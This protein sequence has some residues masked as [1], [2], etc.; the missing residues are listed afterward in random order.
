MLHVKV[1]GERSALDDVTGEVR[2][3]S[4]RT[5]ALIAYLALHP[6]TPQ[7]RTR[8]AET[9]W[10]DSEQQQALTN[11]RREL[12]ELRRLLDGD[13]S[14]VVTG[15]DLT[16][17]GT[18]ACRVDLSEHLAARERAG[19]STS[20]N[21]DAL[22]VHG[23]QAL[24]DYGGDLLPGLYDDWV[25]EQRAALV[26]GARE[27]CAQVAAAAAAAQ[28]WDLAV[29]VARRRIALDPLDETAYRE[30]MRLQAAHGDRAGA[31]S[32]YHRCAAV[33]EEQLGVPPDPESQRLRDDLVA[34]AD[35]DDAPRPD[36]P[37][38]PPR[39]TAGPPR[40]GLVARGRELEWLERVYA[41]VE[42]GALRTVLVTGEPGVGKSRLVREL[43]HRVTARGARVATAHCYGTADRLPLGPVAEWLGEPALSSWSE[44][45]PP[46]WRTEVERLL[47]RDDAQL[48]SADTRGVVD[49]WQR[50]HFFHGLCEA[51]RPPGR[52]VVL[53]LENLQWCDQE[54]LE[55][56]TFLRSLQPRR[57]VLV[58][59]TA[60]SHELTASPAHTAWV[61]RA[62]AVAPVRELAVRPLGPD[63]SAELL[64]RLS[65]RIGAEQAALLH[66]AS[67]GFPLH[68]VEAV[69]RDP[70]GERLTAGSPD[71]MAVLRGRFEALGPECRAVVELA[72][73]VGR[74]FRL[75]LLCAAS[76]LP[77]QA[78]VGAV[79]E[80]WRLRI[81]AVQRD[82]YDFS[83]DLLRR[84]AYEQLTPPARWLLH[85]R[86]ATALEQLHAHDLDPVAGRLADQYARAGSPDRACDLFH[87]AAVLADDVFAYSDA[88]ELFGRSL[89]LLADLPPG[90]GRDAR[91]IRSLTGLARALNASRGY[92]DPD[93]ADALSRVV[94]L[95]EQAAMVPTTVDALVGLWAARFVQGDILRA[96]EIAVKALALS[97]SVTDPG[98]A[99]DLLRA[100]AHFA[101]GG[102]TLSLGRPADSLAHFARATALGADDASLSIGSHPAVHAL[103]WSAHAHWLLGSPDTARECA[104]EAIARARA[105]AHPY[106]LTITLGYAAL[107]HQLLD[108]RADLQA[109]ADELEVVSRRHGFAYYA[110]WGEVLAGWSA[111]DASS[112][113]RMQDAI[114]RLRHVGAFARMPYWLSLL[115]DRTPDPDR[116]LALLDAATVSARSRHDVWWLPD[117]LRRRAALLT[118]ASAVPLLEQARD[119]ALQHGS[120]ALQ[121]RCERDLASRRTLAERHRS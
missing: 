83:H 48:R 67:G 105:L 61:R 112:A 96:H 1:L 51:L 72:S 68:L 65:P 92:S 116:A 36:R 34:P 111:D 115:A 9:F 82:R 79:D 108:H 98:A 118:T 94:A 45:L 109:C 21:A 47:P 73:A 39:V 78:V 46:R 28:R 103:A 4:T 15:T 69:R 84:A 56:L 58:L 63:G 25:L 86:L 76:D 121:R 114:S 88:V 32:T 27:L 81:L 37:L 53:V 85:Q 102:S 104:A 44:T 60:R 119:L 42:R 24:A 100:Q 66:A 57:P 90:A 99:P 106:T 13:G 64:H 35:D 50:H 120:V 95:A 17:T 16:W 113:R 20:S 55:L 75:D 43:L 38:R 23:E 18:G 30:L 14:L 6:G 7:P 10:P 107:T 5:I 89:G 19:G 87:R 12:L 49:V 91:E 97:E 59:L 101:G 2:T 70:D 77:P 54:T 29:R 8:I 80:L 52:P 41:D 11:L 74:E 3:R 71:L 22:L 31:L 117:V 40:S 110:D 26:D 62:R 33:L 93:L